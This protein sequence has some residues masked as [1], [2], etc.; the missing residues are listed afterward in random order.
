MRWWNLGNI[1]VD[2]ESDGINQYFIN[3]PEHIIGRLAKCQIYD[4]RGLTCKR[5]GDPFTR[6]NSF[7]Q[8][9]TS[10]LQTQKPD[11][12]ATK[13][14]LLQKIADIDL[15]LQALNQEKQLICNA[16]K[17]FT[18]FEQELGKLLLEVEPL[19]KKAA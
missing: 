5:E 9:V 10:I 3:H 6:L 14:M 17:R 12:V 16:L 13:A 18:T 4:R 15:K 8:N 11:I 1:R 19:L 2:D 7:L